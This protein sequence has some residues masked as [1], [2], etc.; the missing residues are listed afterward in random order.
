M[1]DATKDNTYLEVLMIED[2]LQPWIV[3]LIDRTFFGVSK[4]RIADVKIYLGEIFILDQLRGV[5]R[6]HISGAED[7]SYTGVYEARGFKKL[8]V[9]SSNLDNRI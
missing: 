4:L 7:L 1:T 9:Y 8:A 6:V 2:P 3:G 5:Y